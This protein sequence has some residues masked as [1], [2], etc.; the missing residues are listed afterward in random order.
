MWVFRYSTEGKTRSLFFSI[1][2]ATLRALHPE[3]EVL[4]QLG[5]ETRLV[6]SEPLRDLPGAR[7]E[8]PESSADGHHRHLRVVRLCPDGDLFGHLATARNM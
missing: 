7:N 3:V 6:V 2:V 8:V 5:P 1:E 4:H